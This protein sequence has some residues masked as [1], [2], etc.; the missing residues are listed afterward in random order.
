[1]KRTLTSGTPEP[2][3][4]VR[5]HPLAGVVGGIAT[6]VACGAVGMVASGPAVGALMALLGLVIGAAGSAHVAESAESNRHL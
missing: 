1:M 6:G 2:V 5:K 3:D 4:A